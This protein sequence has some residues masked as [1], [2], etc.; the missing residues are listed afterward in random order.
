[1]APYI[2]TEDTLVPQT[3]AGYLEKQSGWNPVYYELI[4]AE[5]NREKDRV[6]IEKTFEELLKFVKD[7]N[8][9]E[10]RFM[11]E[12]LDEESLAIFDL[13]SK[14]DLRP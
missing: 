12:G 6:T 1:M 3:T 4:V 2:Y 7:L 14:P 9:E 11:R 5:Y 10:N 13:L 8:E